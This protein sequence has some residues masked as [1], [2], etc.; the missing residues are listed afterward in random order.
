MKEESEKALRESEE[1]Y[2][3]LFNSCIDAVFVHQPTAEGMPGKF[4]EVNEE[5]CRRY[6]YTREELLSLTPSHLSAPEIASGIPDRIETLRT[7]GHVLFETVHVAK[8]GKRIPVEINS[9]LFNFSGTPTV[10]S[11]VRDINDRKRIELALQRS[12][13]QMRAILDASIDRIRHVDRDLGIIW[14]NKTT[15]LALDMPTESVIGQK[16]HKLFLD[17]D[18]PCEGCPTL[19]SLETGRVERAVICQSN[20]KGM[21]GSRYWDTYCVPLKNEAD[22]IETLIQ[23]ARDITKQKVAMNTLQQREETLAAILA[24]SPA[25]IALVNNRILNW[26][27]ESEHRMLGYP[28]GSLTGKNVREL[29]PNDE[30]YERVE[31]E[32]FS[33]AKATGIGKAETRLIRKDGTLIYCYLQGSPLDPQD[34]SKGFIVAAM[35]ISERKQA[36]EHIYSLSHELMKAQESERQMIS[37]ELHDRVAQDLS[38]LK[39][40]ID[41]LL[42]IESQAFTNTRQKISEL[43]KNLQQAIMA[44]RNLSYDLR[45]PSLDQLGPVQAIFQYCE[46][47]AELTGLKVDYASAGME[48]LRF[49]FDTEINLYRLVQEGLNNI[50]KHAGATHA[51]VRLVASHPHII[52]RIEDNGKGFE[53]KKRLASITSEIRMGLRSMQERVNLLGGKIKIQS[54]LGQGTKISIEVPYKEKKK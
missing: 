35:D 40:D 54:R 14:A 17:S 41:T 20:M 25:G 39:I 16:C 46:D 28:E 5:A 12:E 32:L 21:E 45:P 30:E 33:K 19:K 37:R 7:K 11:I 29:C 50:R 52:L 27:N 24:A 47:F 23:V 51:V 1:R 36:Q 18:T 6:G 22:Q 3:Q 31:E 48:G 13:A 2:R 34:P 10:L 4:I 44:V 49:D 43:S 8:D 42:D 38:T 53:V 15:T 9:R 26:A